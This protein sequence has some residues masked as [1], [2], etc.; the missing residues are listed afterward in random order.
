MDGLIMAAQL[1]LSLTILVGIHEWGHYAAARLFKIRVERFYL[2]FD[3]LFPLSNVANFALWKKKIGDTEFGL[4]WFPL[5]GYVKIAG[6]IDETTG[7][8]ALETPIEPWEFR[9]KPAWQ[10][11]IVMLGGIIVNMVAGV[12]IFITL[13]FITGEVF[14]PT[15]E[16]NQHGIYTSPLAKEV[17]LKDG[18]KIV[19]IN[20]K[21]FEKFDE[22]LNPNTLLEAG[23]TY[24]ILRDGQEV[25]VQLPA[26]L[27]EKM[28][29]LKKEEVAFI[30]PLRPFQVDAVV[31]EGQVG[32]FTKLLVS[33]GIKDAPKEELPNKDIDLQKGDKITA[34]NNTPTPY[35]QQFVATLQQY[36]NQQITLT[37]DRQ[38]TTKQVAAQ[39]NQDGKLGIMCSPTFK[40]SNRPYSFGEAIVKGTEAA[41]GVIT[42]QAKGFSKIATGE[43][44]A[45]KAVSGPIGMAKIF[46]AQFDWLAFWRIT[47][48]L[49]MVLA[50]MNLLPIPALD[51]GH[52]IFLLY[53]MAV[54]KAPSESF[55]EKAQQ[56]G[57]MMLLALMVFAFSN[58]IMNVFF[59]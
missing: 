35:Y 31:K 5:G 49:S 44:S 45:T 22:V 40:M 47:A 41:F 54:G 20:G 38:G 34:I 11:L 19:K 48:M 3:F 36:K 32:V 37:I 39:V 8:D 58:D 51:G 56:V 18:D 12:L 33:L 23:T 10:R 42:L 16:V 59:R 29:D 9:A 25:E 6:M 14:L 30:E 26:N 17:G 55:M 13:S 53:E 50:F 24:T 21:A 15:T 52:A 27:L 43:I 46:S 2:F 4:G 1:L 28:S 7:K 57:M